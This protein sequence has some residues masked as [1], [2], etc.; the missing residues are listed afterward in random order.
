MI[1]THMR[2][3]ECGPQSKL[4]NS[5]QKYPESPKGLSLELTSNEHNT[6]RKNLLRVGVWGDVAKAYAGQTA[7][8]EV[9]R[10]D[11]F[12][13]NG[14]TRPDDGVIVWLPQLITQSVQPSNPSGGR[15]LHTTYGIPRVRSQTLCK[16][17][18]HQEVFLKPYTC[19]VV[20]VMLLV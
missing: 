20:A 6:D 4:L 3:Y 5:F 17:C 11:I 15:P 18:A 9:Q 16:H 10:C 13:S 19:D 8:G 1:Y 2:S 14:R 7:E 12:I